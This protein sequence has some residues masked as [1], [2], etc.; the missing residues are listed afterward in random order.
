MEDMEDRKILVRGAWIYGSFLFGSL[1][2]GSAILSSMA[3]GRESKLTVVTG[4][5]LWG[6]MAMKVLPSFF[7]PF[8]KDL[9]GLYPKI[10]KIEKF[11]SLVKHQQTS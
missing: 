8:W 3:F 10:S 1:I 6:C 5:F 7:K 2:L 11:L 4:S 9:T